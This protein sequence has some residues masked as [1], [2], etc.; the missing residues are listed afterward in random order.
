MS[1]DPRALLDRELRLARALVQCLWGCETIFLPYSIKRW[2]IAV[3]YRATKVGQR[4]K[5]VVIL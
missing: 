4:R 2:E 3:L 1:R 5:G